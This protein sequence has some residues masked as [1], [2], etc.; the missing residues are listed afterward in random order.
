MEAALQAHPGV[1]EAAVSVEGAGAQS[2]L[3]AYWSSY[4]SRGGYRLPNGWTVEH[5]NANETRYLYEELVEKGLYL[6]H[7]IGLP[8]GACVLDVGANIGLF[9]MLIAEQ[10]PDAR[11][12]AFEPI[13]ALQRLLQ[14]NVARYGSR[15]RVCGY[16]L[17]SQSGPE[18]FWYYP[19]YTMMS[20]RRAYADPAGDRAVVERYLSQS[21]DRGLASAAPELLAGRFE[22]EAVPA[23]VRRLS[24]VLCEEGLARVDLLKVDV[25]RAEE[26]VLSGL[27]SGDWA[28]VRQVVLEVHDAGSGPTAGRV[29]RVRELLSGRGFEVVVE[30]DPELSGTDRYTAYARRRGFAAQLVAPRQ[31]A[32]T[33]TASAPDGSTLRS[34]LQARVPDYMVPS[35]YVAVEQLPSTSHGKVDRS[36]LS[37]LGERAR[38]GVEQPAA[39]ARTPL[40][41]VV[42]EVWGDVLGRPVGIEDN[43]FDCGG[44]SLLATQVV[45]RLRQTL[46]REV[47]VRL[48]FEAPTVRELASRLGPLV[49]ASG[50]APTPLVALPREGGRVALSFAQQRLWFLAQLEPESVA[51]NSMKALRL[52]GPLQAPALASALSAIVSR[53]EVLRTRLVAGEGEPWGE[54]TPAS[55]LT[56]TPEPVSSDEEVM[57]VVQAE[58]QRPFDLAHDPLLRVR[59]L[60]SGPEEHVLLL[61]LHHIVTDAWSQNVLMQEL[62]GGYAAAC[63]GRSVSSPPL[64][65]QYSDYAQWQRTRLQGP[66]LEELLGYWQGQLSDVPPLA[67]PTD[68]PRPPAPSG[69][70]ATHRFTL[71]AALTERLKALS[72]GEGVT[73]FMTLLA[74]FQVVLSRYAQ[75]PLFA[76]GTP[77]AGRTQAETE[78]LIGCFINMLALRAD[79]RGNPTFRQLLHRVRETCL[80]AYAHQELPFERLVDSLQPDRTVTHAPI[81]QVSFGLQNTP[82]TDMAL[83]EDLS[84]EAL[85]VQAETAKYDLA[86]ILAERD[87]QLQGGLQ[88]ATELFE[89]ATMERLSAHFEQVLGVVAADEERRL[90]EVSLLT[91]SESS[92]LAAWNATASAYPSGLCVHE[93]FESQVAET[94]SAAAV[95]DGTRSLTYAELNGRSNQLARV[96]VGQGV[97]AETAV[98]LCLGRS[99]D[100]VV[101]LLA[102]LKAG[103]A[104]VPLDPSHPAS[105]LQYQVADSGARV[106][107]GDGREAASW[108]GPGVSWVPVSAGGEESATNLALRSGPLHLAYIIYTSGSTGH[109]KGVQV[110]HHSVVNLMTWVRKRWSLRSA[111]RVLAVL[112]VTFDASVEQLLPALAVGA[113]LVI[114]RD[115][116][117]MSLEELDTLCLTHAIS[118]LHLPPAYVRALRPSGQRQGGT[119]V[120]LVVIGGEAS[121]GSDAAH[122]HGLWPSAECINEYGLTET[123]VTASASTA[124][125][126][127][128][129]G[130][131]AIGAPIANTSVHVVDGGMKPVPVGV[132]GELCVGGAGVARGYAGAAG[133]TA[134]RFV[135]DPF[136]EEP[137]ARLYRTGDVVRWRASGELE[138]LG[139]GDHQ[140]K[141]RGHR[142]ELGEVEAVLRQHGDVEQAVVLLREI[143]G[144]PRLVGHVSGGAG[145]ALEGK[146]LRTWLETRVPSYCIPSTWVVLEALP[147]TSHGKLDRARLAELTLPVSDETGAGTARTAVEE[148]LVG[149]WQDVLGVAPIGIND[150]FF[151][152]GGD[153]IL[154]IQVTGRAQEAGLAL[155]PRQLFQ[156]QTIA[157]LSEAL[158]VAEHRDEQQ[159]PMEGAVGLTPIQ[160]WFFERTEVD[161]HH[162]NQ[163]MLLTCDRA[164]TPDIVEAA[165][166]RLVAHHDVLR[167]SFARDAGTWRQTYTPVTAASPIWEYHDWSAAPVAR[168]SAR[169]REMVDAVQ[170]SLEL[171]DG[172]PLR[173]AYWDLG[174]DDDPRVLLVCHHLV[175][176]GVSWRILLD[177]LEMCCTQLLAGKSPRLPLKTA[178]FQQW[179]AALEAYAES[180]AL[181]TEVAYWAT[182]GATVSPLPVDMPS[183]TNTVADVEAVTISFSAAETA[184]LLREA[185]QGAR[186]TVHEILV[187]AVVDALGEWLGRD[188]VR[189]DL[190]GHGREDVLAVEVSRTVGWFTTWYPVALRR[191]GTTPLERI[192]AVATQLREVPHRGIGYGVLRYLS[193][194]TDVAAFRQHPQADV[195]FNYFGQ[196]DGMW[197]GSFS[198]APEGAGQSQSPRH[199][200]FHRLALNGSVRDGHLQMHWTY[201]RRQYAGD[202]IAAV[203]R[204]FEDSVRSVLETVRHR[205]RSYQPSDFPV[206]RLDARELTTVVAGAG[207]APIETVYPLSELQQG[208]LAAS[209]RHGRDGLY[210]EQLGFILDTVPD[211]EQFEEAWRFVIRRHQ[212]LRAFFVWDGVTT[213]QHVVLHDVSFT[214]EWHDWRRMS[215]GRRAKRWTAWLREDRQRGIKAGRPPLLRVQVVRYSARR[216]RLLLTGHHAILDGWSGRIVLREVFEVYAALREGRAPQLAPSGTFEDYI[217][218]LGRQSSAAAE[219]FWRSTVGDLTTA[220]SV[221]RQSV[222]AAASSERYGRTHVTLEPETAQA[223]E[224]FCRQQ[225]G[226]TMAA[227]VQGVWGLLLSTY[228][229]GGD[230]VFGMTTAIRPGTLPN[231]ENTVGPFIHTVPVRWSWAPTAAVATALSTFK[232]HQAAAQEYSYVPLL[233]IQRQSAVPLDQA[234]FDSLVVYQNYPTGSRRG[235][236]PLEEATSGVRTTYPLTLVVSNHR[237]FRAHLVYQTAQVAPPLAEEVL[238]V[239]ATLLRVVVQDPARS[240]EEVGRHVTWSAPPPELS[241]PSRGKVDAPAR[242]PLEEVLSEVWGDVLGRSVG[243]ED[244]FFDGGGHSLLATQVVSRL[245]QTLQREVPLRLLFEAPT[246]RELA[247]RLGPLVEASG[248]APTPLVALPREGGRVALSFAQQRL[249]FLAQLEP[250]SVVY[251]GATALRLRGP[252]Q[253]PAL[254]SALSAIMSRHEVLRTRLVAGEGEPWGEVTPASALALTPEPVSSDEEVMAVVQA[255]SQRP[256]DLAHDPLLRV[257][258]LR[259]GPEEH[260][261]LL[262]LH[263]IVTDAWSQNVL[264]Q[265]LSGGYAAACAGRSVSSPPLPVQ[266]S[267]YAQWQRTRLQGPV[268][269]ELLGYWQGQLSDV[270]P[271]ALPTDRPRPPAPSGRGATHRFTLDA[272]LTERL[273]ALSRGEGVTLFMTL[274]AAFQVVLSRYAQQPLFAVGTP[275]AGRTQAETEGLIGCFINMLALRADLRGNPTFRQLLHRVRETCLGAYAHQELPFERLVDSLQ[276]DRTVTHAPIFQV[277]FGLQNTPRTDMALGE[278]LSVEALRVQAETAKYDLAL[279]LAERDGQL[280]GGLQYATELF[281]SATMERL[282]AHFEQVLGVVAADEGLQLCDVSALTPA[283]RRRLVRGP[284]VK[285]WRGLSTLGEVFETTC[286]RHGNRIAVSGSGRELTY[287]ELDALA[288]RVAGALIDAG[289]SRGE[290]VGI[291]ID[292]TPDAVVAQVGAVKAGAVFVPLDVGVPT[293]RMRSMVADAGI[294]VILTAGKVPEDAEIDDIRSI[295]VRRLDEDAASDVDGCRAVGLDELAYVIFT[296]GSTGRPKGVGVTHRNVSRLLR[297]TRR[298]FR[299]R[300]TDVW[301]VCHALGFDFSI[302]EIWGALLTGGCAV[303]VPY[304]TVRSPEELLDVISDKQITILSQTPSAF[305][306]LSSVAVERSNLDGWSVR[307]IVFGGESLQCES[308]R[309]WVTKF[310]MDTPQ[311][312]NMYGITEA[313]VHTTYRALGTDDVSEPA[314]SVIG[315]ALDDC[316]VYVVDGGMK[317]VPVGAAGELYIG[318]AGVAREYV[319]APGLTASRFVP[320]PFGEEP[321]ARLYRTG[322][323]VRW[324]ASGELEYLGRGDHQVKLRGHRIELGE[325]EAVLRQHGDV[326]QAVVLLHRTGSP[327]RLVAYVAARAGGVLE[328]SAVRRWMGTRL[329]GYMVPS[330]VVVVEDFPLTGHGKVDRRALSRLPLELDERGEGVA[331][332]T[333]L[334]EVVSEVWGDV[335]GHPVGIEDN[336]FDC[337][338]H[339]LLA[340][341][342]VSRLRQTLQREVPVRL[343][344][345]APTVRELASRLGPLVGASGAAPTPL[346]ALPREGGRV[347]LSFAQQRLWFLAQLEPES[348][349]YN[350]MKALRLRGPLQAPALASALSAIVSRHEVLRTRL[351][352]GEG[353]PW[354]EVT[355]AS[356]LTLTPEPVSSDEEVMAVVQAESQRPFDLAHDPLLRVRLLRS[357]PEEHVLLLALHHIVTDA[358]SQN[359]LMQELSGGYAAACAG[360]SVPSPPLPVQYSDYAQWQRTR[361]QGPVLEELLGYWQGQLSDVPPLALPTDRPRPPALSGR[362]ATHRFT[363][364]AALTER[365]KALSRGEGV[366]LFM[367]LLAAFQVV[368]SRYAQQPLFAVGTPIAGRAQAET[369]GLIGCFINMLALRADLRGNPT[370]RQLLHR[371]RE[372]CLGA[373]A[374]QELPFERLVDSLQPHRTATLAPIFQV[375]F[376]LQNTPRTDIFLPGLRLEPMGHVPDSVRYDITLW[377]FDRTDK[378]ELCWSYRNELFDRNTIE[379]LNTYFERV[380]LLMSE[381]PAQ[382]F[383][384]SRFMRDEKARADRV[385]REA[386][387]Q[388]TLQKVR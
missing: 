253:A 4:I 293:E 167:L 368:L 323:V 349:A 286:R 260:V 345:E 375:S 5:A 130:E 277:S 127:D 359:V 24:D 117:E 217:R 208:M 348:V 370:F 264:M 268:L 299:F 358:W 132:A 314:G 96:L 154:S 38:A 341:Q 6:R 124:G 292:R 141:L 356:A 319:G 152:R 129:G 185:P 179:S 147:V 18:T 252:L 16:G 162:F 83:G 226:L 336:F 181:A 257:R 94:P 262:T 92:A 363:L 8:S 90:S 234:L 159:G 225:Q 263:H 212:I 361:L 81:F 196:L 86:L 115:G 54:V 357:G 215:S 331:P 177:D 71:D 239:F 102:V 111:D 173:V 49:G 134:S 114:A 288:G 52:R 329:P 275:I 343:L 69:R 383:K 378:L 276:P 109:P 11:V 176:D 270:P 241:S 386:N 155:A 136:G 31:D 100:M 321:G 205:P 307:A 248:A 360:R 238:A 9:S 219:A 97:G 350:S 80:G 246:I 125:R 64:P 384:R 143:D 335:L 148:V 371:V 242:T 189:L 221:P 272:A 21:A 140:V 387:V 144:R 171:S 290:C 328:A 13:P 62:S 218:W 194:R 63:A 72:R 258:L 200:R 282:S 254:A 374:H 235:A 168:R 310:G 7:G 213:P 207:E 308:L 366:T 104:Y 195:S 172:T 1:R 169:L 237:E 165:V 337:G 75:Q 283:E 259:S 297:A 99:V 119:A 186:V 105:R 28:K 312:I 244:D 211:R 320:D 285:E 34:W 352:A 32:S 339:S 279:I 20:G 150:N 36:A 78:G 240:M 344:F 74:A 245:R 192:Q 388:E 35:E 14:R 101:A 287:R 306:Q 303:V 379:L 10:W 197:R 22:G 37:A 220:T 382:R 149:I 91:G 362:G 79:L 142:I 236:A 15:V 108:T 269:E 51:Y 281:E 255:E 227:L 113:T 116:L 203:A 12:W 45:S 68:R 178:S 222:P 322:D 58:S 231:M 247:S 3:V 84:V 191:E 318:G 376:G 326:E 121:S 53:H 76:V 311:L 373:Y 85:R 42:S 291:R 332:R 25:Q 243:V 106:V 300:A 316:S 228:N 112:P 158:D 47:P 271:L 33:G 48:L 46:Q 230:A 126:L 182:A 118:I 330:A 216:S 347:A 324:R 57:A 214:C 233:A 146:V 160:R 17:S 151:E 367:T 364:D 29:E 122:L 351:V 188:V 385:R 145:K 70:G 365:L 98:A 334:E 139:R 120:R 87:G 60:R 128:G 175:V 184:V 156:H 110:A 164:L 30:Q 380:V 201:S 131:V 289:V 305:Q 325:V 372:T 40:E 223:A 61:A 342:V 59:L 278:D 315:V 298:H 313:T 294:R 2:T 309:P 95:S 266:Y 280:Q 93:L 26:D 232:E 77:I 381:N 261:L 174:P 301:A 107:V 137:G 183:G 302:W 224:R 170:A 135:P 304:S 166:R 340:T 73:L 187:G 157:A 198:A 65:V 133:L 153:S 161:P 369:E 249:W 66:V 193:R 354:G 163:A 27:E 56:L 138:Y 273:K 39:A 103:G 55:A 229:G 296:S 317:P 250:E 123:C 295:D 210:V 89:S 267:D 377:I 327:E 353:E 346:V 67:L 206:A 333:P 82:R 355:P 274:L 23:T 204:A 19:R 265:E 41:E 180:D 284:R 202:T 190:E 209:L 338:G 44:H 50:A 43:F 251:N 199:E 88:Y 256:F